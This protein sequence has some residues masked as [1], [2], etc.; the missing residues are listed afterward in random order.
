MSIPFT[1]EA[2]DAYGMRYDNTQADSAPGE[3]FSTKWGVTEESWAAALRM[4]IVDV[5]FA[6]ATADLARTIRRADYWNV[7]HCGSLAPG[8]AYMVYSA[9]LLSGTG[10]IA[11][12]V[13]RIVGASQ[14]GVI[15]R[16]TLQLA[17]QFGDKALMD[18]IWAANAQHF[19]EIGKP[20]FL[21]GW[22][23]RNDEDIAEAYQMA[24]ISTP[25]PKSGPAPV[26]GFP[27]VPDDDAETDA[28]ND[29]EAQR[30]THPPTPE[31]GGSGE[32]QGTS[33]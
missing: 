1:F 12:T 17:N 23:V 14:D 27:N 33:T 9:G 25:P 6:Q 24:G 28:L 29:A 5:P 2:C 22:T 10:Y 18:A 15:G 31:G 4:G 3:T 11:R 13:Q 19:A 16:N 21:H 20:Q 30:I 26:G 32:N 7:L 8:V